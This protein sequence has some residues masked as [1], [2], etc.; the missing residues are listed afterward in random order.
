MSNSPDARDMVR[1]VQDYEDR[2]FF[3]KWHLKVCSETPLC[4]ENKPINIVIYYC[5]KKERGACYR[6]N[7]EKLLRHSL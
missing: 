6:R 1:K 7:K 5:F 4:E 3:F 2:F